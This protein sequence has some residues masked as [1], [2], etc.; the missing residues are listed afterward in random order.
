MTQA[1]LKKGPGR[2]R[3][4]LE[5]ARMR[6][7]RDE[8][9][10]LNEIAALMGCGRGTGARALARVPSA[11][12]PP[13]EPRMPLGERASELAR[14]REDA[15]PLDA[16]ERR[17]RREHARHLVYRRWGDGM[18]VEG[19]DFQPAVPKSEGTRWLGIA[20]IAGGLLLWA[21]GCPVPL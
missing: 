15:A 8:G 9:K 12:E 21:M 5:A 19:Q 20:L 11:P 1:N 10:T 7:L 18:Q 4:A 3:R 17:R 14:G 16:E 13:L 2:P 6:R